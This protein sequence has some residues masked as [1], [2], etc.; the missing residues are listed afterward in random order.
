[1][2]RYFNAVGSHRVGGLTIN[3]FL[4]DKILF[5]GRMIDVLNGQMMI[6]Y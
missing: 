1:M 2:I 3:S 4:K 5:Y 6:V